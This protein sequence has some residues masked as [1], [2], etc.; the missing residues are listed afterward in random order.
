MH[1]PRRDLALRAQGKDGRAEV[2]V[3]EEVAETPL[4][5]QLP[6]EARD[7][8]RA[9]RAARARAAAASGTGAHLDW[10]RSGTA[11]SG[12]CGPPAMVVYRHARYV[13]DATT[14][15]FAALE[16]EPGGGD[17]GTLA[18][19]P[20]SDDEAAR[21]LRLHGANVIAVPVPPVIVL[22]LREALH[23]FAIFQVFAVRSQP[24]AG[25]MAGRVSI[26]RAF[27]A[28]AMRRRVVTRQLPS[29]TPRRSL[30]G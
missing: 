29:I 9:F 4:E 17:G 12:A 10:G 28:P 19:A 26:F 11:P 14:R 15:G 20:L 3:V 23:P 13:L 18:A 24:R 7:R 30:C 1:V 8:L 22:L 5:L 16:V 27:I 21:R 6:G 25:T 2:C